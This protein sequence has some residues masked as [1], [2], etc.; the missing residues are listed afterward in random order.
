MIIKRY[1]GI[2]I[3]CNKKR[4]EGGTIMSNPV[5]QNLQSRLQNNINKAIKVAEKNTRKNSLG[6]VVLSCNDEWRDVN[7]WNGDYDKE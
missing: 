3:R 1:K 6:Q 4:N 2:S 5:L 7:E